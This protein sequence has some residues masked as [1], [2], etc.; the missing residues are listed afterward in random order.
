MFGR[1]PEIDGRNRDVCQVR[2]PAAE[3]IFLSRAAHHEPTAVDPQQR[4]RRI[5]K[6]RGTM[7]AHTHISIDRHHRHV[8]N[9]EDAS[10]QRHS[11]TLHPKSTAE[12]IAPRENS[13][14][15]P[16]GRVHI[17][18]RRERGHFWLVSLRACRPSSLSLMNPIKT[19]MPAMMAATASP[20]RTFR[21]IG[22]PRR[23][24]NPLGRRPCRDRWWTRLL[25]IG[26]L[27]PRP[28]QGPGFGG[29]VCYGPYR[30]HAAVT[31]AFSRPQRPAAQC[32]K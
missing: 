14:R 9:G 21:V 3:A 1:Q 25:G 10:Q 19:S 23:G 16:Q 28:R 17:W 2:Q 5:S 26:F 30:C 18:S 27:L 7:Q 13:G 24:A 20:T 8:T 12:G 32:R 11:R 22:E 15:S 4:R 29:Q 6:A 31:E